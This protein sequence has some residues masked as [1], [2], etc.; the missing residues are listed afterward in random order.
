MIDELRV[1]D[2]QEYALASLGGSSSGSRGCDVADCES[3]GEGGGAGGSAE[4]GSAEVQDSLAEA[5]GALVPADAAGVVPVRMLQA[6][7]RGP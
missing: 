3:D 7:G 1:I 5:A 2:G 4:D 6:G